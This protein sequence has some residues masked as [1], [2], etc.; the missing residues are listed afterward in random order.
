MYDIDK[1]PTRT[2]VT[3]GI[4]FAVG[5]NRAC[6]KR[7]LKPYAWQASLCHFELRKGISPAQ[8]YKLPSFWLITRGKGCCWAEGPAYFRAGRCHVGDDV[9][10]GRVMPDDETSDSVSLFWRILFRQRGL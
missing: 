6:R 9:P 10:N 1:V 5:K 8:V 2:V 7:A 4:T 3:T